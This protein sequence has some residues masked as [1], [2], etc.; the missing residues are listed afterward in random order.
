MGA[1]ALL[2]QYLVFCGGPPVPFGERQGVYDG[3]AAAILEVRKPASPQAALY[4]G[5]TAFSE[6][7]ASAGI[8]IKLL[9]CVTKKAGFSD[10]EFFHYWKNVHGPIGARIPGLRRLVQSHRVRFPGDTR[11]S[12]FDGAAELWFDD[13]AALLAARNSPEWKAST[14]DES[15]FIDR[16]KVAYFLSEEHIIL[17]KLGRE[18]S[19]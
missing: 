6:G 2:S 3:K 12:D 15:N 4:S 7:S 18:P 11:S 8:M 1:Q 5:R 19:S 17:D 14:A 13:F 16:S 10:E 9:Y